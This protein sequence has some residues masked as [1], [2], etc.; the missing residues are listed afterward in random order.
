ML[1]VQEF[2][3]GVLAAL[4]LRGRSQFPLNERFHFAMQ[5]AFEEMLRTHP[6]IKARF[7]IRVHPLHQVS[8]SVLDGIH[9][10]LSCGMAELL[11]P[12]PRELRVMLSAGQGSALL[13]AAEGGR[14]LYDELAVV[15]LD[16][17]AART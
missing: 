5:R 13:E 9:H 16:V 15:F 7:C 17:F 6:E 8:E 10:A 3:V 4:A 2:C 1:Y 12:S 14:P 11:G